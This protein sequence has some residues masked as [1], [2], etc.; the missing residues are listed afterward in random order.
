MGNANP[1]KIRLIQKIEN[2]HRNKHNDYVRFCRY[3][4]NVVPYIRKRRNVELLLLYR[5]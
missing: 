1:L 4:G 2:G 5:K 3:K